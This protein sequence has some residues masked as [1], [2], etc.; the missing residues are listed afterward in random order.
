MRTPVGGTI[1]FLTGFAAMALELTAVR[2][3]APS[4]G[5]S[6][7][8][9]TN[10]IGVLLA[11]LAG[12]AWLGGRLADRGGTGRQLGVLLLLAAAATTVVP[13]IAP[14]LGP[15]L[16]PQDLPLDAAQPALIR[17]SLAATFLLFAPPVLLIGCTTP[18]LVTLLAG[19][20]VAVG[21][22][23]GLVSAWATIGSLSGTF[24]ATHLLVPLLGSRNTAWTCAAL[25]VLAALPLVV[26]RGPAALLLLLP[27]ASGL[28]TRGPLEGVAAGERLMAERE[29]GYQ[30]LQVVERAEDGV[31]T[32]LLRINEG[33]DSFHSVARAGTP[34]TGGRYYDY[35]VVAPWLAGDGARPL[36]LRVLSLGAAAGTFETLF[37]AAH[38][39]VVLD[40]VEIDPAVVDLGDRWFGAARSGRKVYPGVDARVFVNNAPPGYHVVL[41]D[42]YERQIYIPAHVASR[43]FFAQVARVLA[44]GGVVSVNVG[45]R[46]FA[47]PVV[48]T[49]GATMATVFGSAEAF[50]VPR[51]RNFVLLARKGGPLR[52]EA[53]A[54]IAAGSPELA[55]VL[56]AMRRPGSWRTIRAGD[57]GVLDDDHPFLDRLHDTA[58]SATGGRSGLLPCRGAEPPGSVA[59][60]VAA[61]LGDADPDAA[62]TEIGKAAGADSY[63]RLLAGDARWRLHD[64]QGAVL[65]Y[66]EADRLGA[67]PAFA[68]ALTQRLRDA[69]DEAG[70]RRR[71]GALATRNAWLALL[72]CALLLAMGMALARQ[73]RP[74]PAGS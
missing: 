41:V 22:A 4:F 5:D 71:A 7:Y 49:M 21:R 8:V 39:G 72:A 69:R 55:A 1:A 17:A 67:D 66:E 61:L 56:D 32:T 64:V 29:S 58:Y 74:A 46:T 60:R 48:R 33:L 35:H 34:W 47:D 42:A 30:Y 27:L 13:W 44:Q 28:V 62:L 37:A 11:A 54:G 6:T 53:L 10:V 68:A 16:L 45:G 20:G 51:S 63:L 36:G 57:A 65:E 43:E 70:V 59:A 23:S 50:R 12:G 19:S 14:W 3:M 24:A 2:L 25:L 9:W 38:P 18:W 26:R 31:P 73:A 40:A 52:R 15:L